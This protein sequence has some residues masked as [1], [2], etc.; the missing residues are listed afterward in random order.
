MMAATE[1]QEG[2]MARLRHIA[3]V[4]KD[5]DKAAGFYSQVFEFKSSPAGTSKSARP[6]T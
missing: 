2:I 5:I 3:L 1:P 4:V 6:S